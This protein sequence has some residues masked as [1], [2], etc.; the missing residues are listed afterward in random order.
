MESIDDLF[1]F[2]LKNERTLVYGNLG[3][4]YQLI[5]EY[6]IKNLPT[7]EIIINSKYY[8]LLSKEHIHV[9]T[10]TNSKCDIYIF[11]E[12]EPNSIITQPDMALRVVVFASH[13]SINTLRGIT[14]ARV[15]YFH[16][17]NPINTEIENTKKLISL[18]QN[19]IY[20]NKL[21]KI[22]KYKLNF[23]EVRTVSV[24]IGFNA[25]INDIILIPGNV[26][27]KL[28][29]K[30]V[31]IADLTQATSA[32]AIYTYL[33]DIIDF[34]KDNIDMIEFWQVC[35]PQEYQSSFE[36]M[37]KNN[38]DKLFCIKF[39][40]T[41]VS[42][43]NIILIY[44]FYNVGTINRTKSCEFKKFC[45][46]NYIAPAADDKAYSTA[47]YYNLILLTHDIYLDND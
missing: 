2:I 9:N 25:S 4:N 32:G 27:P 5:Y 7:F 17:H 16:L 31:I 12:P 47:T 20:M 45:H 35:F 22:F 42:F 24:N 10:E 46:F 36:Y 44:P 26:Y 11:I 34:L 40:Y 28:Y 29:K 37:I 6:I 14:W 39:K 18:K 1:K 38:I 8:N 33:L 30:T 21:D 43:Y 41:N 23:D 15:S 19:T 3:R 13:L